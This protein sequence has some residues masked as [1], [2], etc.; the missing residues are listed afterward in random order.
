ML[1]KPLAGDD[2]IYRRFISRHYIR[3]DNLGRMRPS[4]AAFERRSD[5]AHASCYIESL[6]RAHEL[7]PEDVLYKHEALGLLYSP[8]ECLRKHERDAAPD[9]EGID[10]DHAHKCDPAHGKLIEPEG[11]SKRTLKVGWGRFAKDACIDVLQEPS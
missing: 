10:S 8:V 9:P 3:D 2:G 4:S 1:D 7:K 6:L 11:L 5:E